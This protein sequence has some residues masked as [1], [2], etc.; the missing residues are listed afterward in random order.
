MPANVPVLCIPRVYPN[1]TES[2]I[3]RIFNDLNMGELDRI[4]IISKFNEKGEKFNRVFVHF[5]AWN[6]SENANMSRE[7][8]LNGKEIKIVYDDP[9]FW[10]VS[11]YREST[12]HKPSVAPKRKPTLQFD[13]DEEVR[14]RHYDSRPRNPETRH[15]DSRPRNPETRPRNQKP[16][17]S[18]PN[19]REENVSRN[20]TTSK[21]LIGVRPDSD[22]D[23]M[24]PDV[25]YGEI[26]FPILRKKQ[27]DRIEEEKAN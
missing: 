26:S 19:Y 17:N 9:W 20:D 27:V 22:K 15:Y 25:D 14:T 2:R 6:N 1:I 3:R 13:S 16:R 23:D 21:R 12:E 11:A 24:G 4:D 5:R 18:K 8:L 7:R 10:K